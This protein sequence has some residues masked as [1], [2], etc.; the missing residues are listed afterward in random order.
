LVATLL[1]SA[2]GCG[3]RDA[4]KQRL[5]LYHG[6]GLKPP[7]AELVAEFEQERGVTVECVPQGS[8]LLLS[9]IK[10]LRRGDL[11]LPG[12][13]SYVEQARTEGLIANSRDICYFVPVI[14]VAKDAADPP[15][16]LADLTR[17]G[18]RLG[19]GD[20]KA[21]AIGRTSARLMSKN[22]IPEAA[23]KPNVETRALTVHQLGNQVRLGH[24]DAAIVWDAVAAQF[25]DSVDVVRIPADQNVISRVS[26]GVLSCS[27][28]PELADEFLQFATSDRGREVFRKHGYCVSLP[29]NAP[30][31]PSPEERPRARSV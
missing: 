8:E 5:L 23:Y 2:V 3:G 20:A 1:L 7:V 27:R 12:D 22:N 30:P 10:T 28:N 26:L 13:T 14:I 25:S 16:S 4:G 21:C 9:Q 18:L 19:L 31:D 15:A 11:F 17:P 29:D 6:A 24:L